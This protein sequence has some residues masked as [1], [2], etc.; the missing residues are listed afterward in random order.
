[1][2][3]HRDRSLC[4]VISAPSGAGKTTLCERLLKEFPAMTYS[5]SC[6]TRSSRECEVDGRDYVF[7]TEPEFQRRMEAGD[8]LEYARVHG[9]WYGTRRHDVEKTLA[10][11][12]DV[13]MDIDVKGAECIRKLIS[14]SPGSMLQKAFLDVFIVP[15]DMETLKIRLQRRGQDPEEDIRCR[16]KNAEREMECWKDYQYVIVN[17]RLDEA[18]DRL[19]SVIRAE[20]CRVQA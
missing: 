18:Y 19:R 13:L 14:D 2:T 12:R 15:P 5:V 6:T 8:F 10:A 16:L 9:H 17:D 20:H 1:M 4:V 7:L 11:G 3:H